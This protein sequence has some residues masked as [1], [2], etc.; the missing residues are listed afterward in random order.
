MDLEASPNIHE[1]LNT[2]LSS[3]GRRIVRKYFNWSI[4]SYLL[5]SVIPAILS[6]AAAGV[7]F[8]LIIVSF[9]DGID[10]PVW[11]DITVSLLVGVWF[12]GERKFFRRKKVETKHEE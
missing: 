12:S 11:A 10:H 8:Y 1:H 4:L 9:H 7:S 2:S 5:M 6:L 3:N